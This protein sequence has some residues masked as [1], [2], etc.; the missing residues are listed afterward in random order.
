M[1]NNTRERYNAYLQNIATANHVPAGTNF[2]NFK[3]NVDPS[4]HQSFEDVMKHSAGFLGRI[5]IHTVDEQEGEK[6]GLDINTT[7]ASTTNTLLKDREPQDTSQVLLLDRYRCEQTNFDTVMRYAKLDFW[8]KFTDFEARIS[9]HQ[10][11][12][13]ARDRLMIAWN[14][15]KRVTTSDRGLYPLLNDVN[16]GWIE[17]LRLA[18]PQRILKEGEIASNEIRVGRL[19]VPSDKHERG[20][21]YENGDFLNVDAMIMDMVNNLIEEWYQEDTGLVV[22]IGREIFNDKFFDLVNNFNEPTERNAL[23]IILA[24]KKVGGL[25]AVRV[26]FFQKRGVFITRIDNLSIYS[27]DNTHRTTIVDNAKRDR[28]E[29]YR[30]MNE[31]YVLEDY[32]MA[33]YAESDN[34]KFPT[35]KGTWE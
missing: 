6:L 1:R 10:T 4:V 16:I 18:A 27:Q 24:N 32:G 5:N 14:G 17:K 29:T 20:Y 30:S 22:I 15:V 25:P 35:S 13:V 26:P 28:I 9:N 19:K 3:F 8:A 7:I 12:Q 23:D 11:L 33:C 31:S 21:F 34:I 2:S